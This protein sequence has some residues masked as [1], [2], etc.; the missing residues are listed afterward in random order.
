MRQFLFVVLGIFMILGGCYTLYM[1]QSDGMIAVSTCLWIVGLALCMMA[2]PKRTNA[3]LDTQ[4]MVEL[5]KMPIESLCKALQDVPTPL[6]RPWLCKI[7]SIKQPVLVYGPDARGSYIYARWTLGM[8]YLISSTDTGLLR[9]DA[10]N[11]W[12]LNGGGRRRQEEADT[13]YEDHISLTQS[14]EAYAQF[15]AAYA[16]KSQVP[17][18][19]TAAKIFGEIGV[20][21]GKLYAFQE[22]FKL[23][24][25]RFQMVDMEGKALYDIEGTWPLKTLRIYAAG[26]DQAVFRVTKRIFH[27]LPQYDFY[28]GETDDKLL[29]SFHKK[30]DFVHDSFVMQLGREEL[31]MRSAAAVIGANYI[32]RLD[33]R[34]IGTIGENLNLTLHNL[35]FDNMVIEVFDDSYTLL[36]AALAVMSAR[37]MARDREE[38]EL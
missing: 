5:P 15:F 11:R 6:G 23:T 13:F 8:F 37:E 12:R 30:L 26:S 25:Q 1:D 19:Q 3:A 35:L 14:L 24:G 33:G 29:G 20:S 7:F 4:K 31:S 9:P 27:L 36:M 34:Q 16:E 10:S 21:Q 2:S 28:T 22:D 38:T 18:M 17:D 32:V